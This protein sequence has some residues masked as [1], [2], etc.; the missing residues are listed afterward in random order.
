[1]LMDIYDEAYINVND[2]ED[3]HS[4]T[5]SSVTS[6]RPNYRRSLDTRKLDKDFFQLKRENN[7]K[8]S[9][10]GTLN[11]PCV[12]IRNAVNGYYI[13]DSNNKRCRVG[14]LDEDLFFSVKISMLGYDQEMRKLFYDN[15]EQCERHLRIDISNDIKKKWSE[16]YNKKVASL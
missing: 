12:S 10:Y 14:S 3:I 15:P 13:T 8:I 1:M 4:E 9:G 6:I 5:A 7:R 2:N 11:V 16:K